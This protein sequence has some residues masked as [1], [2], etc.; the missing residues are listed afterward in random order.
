M[1]NDGVGHTSFEVTGNY[2]YQWRAHPANA[3]TY[4]YHCHVNTV[5]HVQMGLLGALIIDPYEAEAHP[6][7]QE[8][9]PRRAGRS[10][11]T[12][13]STSASGRST[14]ST[15]RWHELNHAAGLCFE[16]AGLNDF[17]PAVLRDRPPLPAPRRPADRGR[18]AAARRGQRAAGREHPAAR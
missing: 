14:R 11:A 17:Q 7:R 8:A 13:P 15:P 4:F 10:G 9:A 2:M 18:R 12:T 5:L 6:R 3:G 1:D 16:D